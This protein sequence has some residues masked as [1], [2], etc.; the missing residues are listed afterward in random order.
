MSKGDK[1]DERDTGGKGELKTPLSPV[2]DFH[3][4]CFPDDIAARALAKL[5]KGANLTPYVDGTVSGL[6][7]SM[8][9]G[10]VDCSVVLPVAVK[11]EHI[12][13]TNEWMLQQHGDGIFS[14]AS[15]HPA[16]KNFEDEI[17]RIRDM[18]FRGVKLH[19]EY[20]EFW[21]DD[22]ALRPFYRAL[23]KAGLV[24]V[25]HAGVDIG[26]MDYVRGTPERFRRALPW[27]EGG[28][29]VL[30]HFG[31]FRVQDEVEKHLAGQD[32]WFDTSF[33]QHELSAEVQV[34]LIRS[35]GVNRVLF[36]TDSPWD[37]QAEQ[38]AAFRKLPLTEA[39]KAAI[40]GGNAAGLLLL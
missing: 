29:V 34:R 18:G 28:V 15:L 22:E 24:T 13:G 17:L 19:P 39:E 36:G 38:V 14:F 5:G 9:R 6:R 35:H 26:L 27:F 33:A 20:Q 31:G 4:H 30:A 32:V 2:I 37:D 1:R 11:P 10:G 23:G 21:V 3:T 25:F 7:S 16:C 8:K 12:R 40:L